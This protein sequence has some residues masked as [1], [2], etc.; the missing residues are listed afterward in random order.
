M[1]TYCLVRAWGRFITKLGGTITHVQPST[2]RSRRRLGFRPL[3]S[4]LSEPESSSTQSLLASSWRIWPADKNDS[5]GPQE[6]ASPKLIQPHPEVCTRA[7][8]EPF[9]LSGR[10]HP[11]ILNCSIS[12]IKHLGCAENDACL[13]EC[14][15]LGLSLSLCLYTCLSPSISITL[16]S[17]FISLSLSTSRSIYLPHSLSLSLSLCPSLLT[18]FPRRRKT[19]SK[20]LSR[21]SGPQLGPAS[22]FCHD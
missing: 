6:D 12:A 19:V 1:G 13:G 11:P 5:V 9:R 14:K 15:L 2:T 21:D 22:M 8:G 3:A 17:T 20:G 16:H 18:S 10:A 4:C 7:D